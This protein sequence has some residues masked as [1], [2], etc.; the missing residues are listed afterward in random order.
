MFPGDSINAVFVEIKPS[1]L[2][3]R[4]DYVKAG[5]GAGK[6]VT[7]LVMKRA[8]IL[9]SLLRIPNCWANTHKWSSLVQ[10]KTERLAL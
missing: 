10:V 5:V 8:Y 1:N 4:V 9:R 7:D 3:A 6:K 2:M